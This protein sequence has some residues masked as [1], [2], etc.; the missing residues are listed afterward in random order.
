V[1]GAE[2]NFASFEPPA[3]TPADDN[4]MPNKGEGAQAAEAKNSLG[5]PS[6]RQVA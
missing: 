2:E 1:T 3:Q 6:H 5:Y 4:W